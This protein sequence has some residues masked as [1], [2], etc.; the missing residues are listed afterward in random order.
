MDS[1][2]FPGFLVGRNISLR[3]LLEWIIRYKSQS[4]LLMPI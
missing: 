4:A 2:G 3:R 1:V